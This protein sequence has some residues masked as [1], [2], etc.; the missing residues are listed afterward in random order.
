MQCGFALVS[1]VLKIHVMN[2]RVNNILVNEP[3]VEI[4]H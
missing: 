4:K 2:L 1:V 3:V